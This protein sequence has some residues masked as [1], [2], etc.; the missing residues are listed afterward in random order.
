MRSERPAT[1]S[2]L[3]LPCARA[4]RGTPAAARPAALKVRNCRRPTGDDAAELLHMGSLLLWARC[5]SSRRSLSRP[6]RRGGPDVL[7][8]RADPSTLWPVA[9]KE[10]HHARAAL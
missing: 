10:T 3:R 4:A 6:R 5:M 2:P 7:L 1:S 8:S 9:H